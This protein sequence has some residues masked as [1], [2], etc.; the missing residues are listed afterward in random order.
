LGFAISVLVSRS[1]GPSGKGQFD[2]VSATAS[3]LTLLTLGVSLPG[4]I[5]WAV[6]GRRVDPA[7]LL[8][9]LSGTAVIQGVVAVVLLL[10]VGQ[11][12]GVDPAAGMTI[13]GSIGVIVAMLALTSYV[14]A[15]IIGLDRVVEAS[16]RDVVGRIF[17]LIA[18]AAA[19]AWALAQGAHATPTEVIVAFAV[20][21]VL[22]AIVMLLG[23]TLPVPRLPHRSQVEGIVRFSFPTYLGHV[24]Q[25]LNN[26]MDLFLVAFFRDTR[27]VGLYALAGSLGQLVGLVS[28]SAAVVLFARVSSNV[29]AVEIAA[30][31]SARVSRELVWAAGIAAVGLAIVGEPLLTI[32][33][34][35]DFGAAYVPLLI[36][37]PGLVAFASVNVLSAHVAG[38]GRPRLNLYVSLAGLVATLVLD[39]TLIPPFGMYGAA[40]ASTVSYLSGAVVMALLFSRETGI[41]ARSLIPLP[42]DLVALARRLGPLVGRV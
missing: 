24:A 14:R 29:E 21:N 7:T 27:E 41:R 23:A 18:I 1:L 26:R 22:A 11:A 13:V 36:L 15:E 37:L 19:I 39:L 4:G 6:A 9:P 40:A 34:G 42:A 38:L 30:D 31:R 8:L 16:V 25:F 10:V 17:I 20:G 35:S 2:L 33:F 5:T 3:L 12:F 28:S 32:V